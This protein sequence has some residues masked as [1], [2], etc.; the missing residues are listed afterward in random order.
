M[1]IEVIAEDGSLPEGRAAGIGAEEHR[2]PACEALGGSIVENAPLDTIEESPHVKA[3]PKRSARPKAVRFDQKA[4]CEH[5]SSSS[6][7]EPKVKA[8]SRAKASAC[9]TTEGAAQPQSGCLEEALVKQGSEEVPESNTD[10]NHETGTEDWAARFG[11]E[12]LPPRWQKWSRPASAQLK[13]SHSPD[14]QTCTKA[15]SMLLALVATPLSTHQA[16]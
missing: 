13:H 8:K 6:A 10:H 5:G 7:P 3:K 1:E 4:V 16:G 15:G 9:R 2:A 11:N 12:R 14:D